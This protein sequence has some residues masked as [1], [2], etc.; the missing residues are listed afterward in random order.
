MNLVL[1]S[2]EYPPQPGGIGD[3][4]KQLGEALKQC[5][6][7]VHVITSTR[8][9]QNQNSFTVL[10]QIVL[11]ISVWN[12]QC[13][14]AIIDVLSQIRPD[15]LHIQYQTGAYGMHPA[16]NFLPWRLS[17]LPGRPKVVVTAHDLL[18]PYLFP[19]AGP[20]RRWVT[21]RLFADADRVVMTNPH[22]YVECQQHYGSHLRHRPGLIPI[23]SNITV[24]PPADYNRAAWRKQHGASDDTVIVAYFGLLSSS[25]GVDTL[26]DALSQLPLNYRLLIIGGAATT[27]QDRKY[28]DTIKQQIASLGLTRR[29]IWTGHCNESDVSAHLLTADVVALP[30]VDGASFRRGS[31]LAALAHGVPVITTHPEQSPPVANFSQLVDGKHA[32]LIPTSNAHALAKAIQKL[33]NNSSLRTDLGRQGQDLTPY[34]SWDAIAD[35]HITLYENLLAEL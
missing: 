23:G 22:D 15:V 19:K 16:I 13:W 1:L 11:P 25:K 28:A 9:N 29:V 34:F 32:L 18:L 6:Q 12:W 35:Q 26:I 17:K 20:A 8:R 30:F 33:T 3:Y 14:S 5:N 31:L 7:A 21:Q 4:T 24:A 2:A 10:P 27:S